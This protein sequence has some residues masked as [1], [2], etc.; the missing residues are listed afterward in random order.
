MINWRQALIKFQVALAPLMVAAIIPI[1][2]IA[3]VV[4]VP[5]AG[6]SLSVANTWLAAQT[7]P[8]N[9]IKIKE[10]SG[11]DLVTLSGGTQTGN[12]TVS[13]PDLGGGSR[14]AAC[15]DLASTFTSPQTF[16]NNGFILKDSLGNLVTLKSADQGGATNDKVFSL[17]SIYAGT[18]V[19]TSDN[20]YSYWFNKVFG[21]T[22]GSPGI[23]MISRSGWTFYIRGA[24]TGGTYGKQAIVPALDADDTFAM[25]GLANTFTN[26]LIVGTAGKGIQIK[27]GSNACMGRVTLVGGTATVNTTAVTTASEIFLTTQ[28]GTVTNVGTPYVASRI[29]LTSF[30]IQ[31][32]NP[33]DVSNVAWRID[34]PAP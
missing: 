30:V 20:S 8:A 32:L 14:T 3:Q 6:V 16:S 23:G 15:I 26:D 2:A 4:V 13:F 19:L 5:S 17:P 29:D 24:A 28:G 34:K 7:F 31:S 21:D 25:L 22:A 27:E 12:G 9:G 10:N 1:A 18:D 33:L 11:S